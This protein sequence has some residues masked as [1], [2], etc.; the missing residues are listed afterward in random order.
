MSKEENSLY[1]YPTLLECLTSWARSLPSYDKPNSPHVKNI[2][3]SKKAIL[4]HLIRTNNSL[5]L[6]DT[7]EFTVLID[8]L[9]KYMTNAILLEI[10]GRYSK[11]YTILEEPTFLTTQDDLLVINKENPY[12]Q[13]MF[14]LE[15]IDQKD[16]PV[17]NIKNKHPKVII[18]QSEYMLK[19]HVY[20][21]HEHVVKPIKKEFYQTFL[22]AINSKNLSIL[23]SKKFS[24]LF[25]IPE[26]SPEF[27]VIQNYKNHNPIVL[28][29]AISQII[30]LATDY[31]KTIQTDTNTKIKIYLSLIGFI[32]PMP[33]YKIPQESKKNVNKILS[34]IFYPENDSEDQ[35]IQIVKD[36]AKLP[37][38]TIQIFTSPY[39]IESFGIQNI[40]TLQDIAKEKSQSNINPETS[41]HNN[42]DKILQNDPITPSHNQTQ[43]TS[44]I[45]YTI[46]S[47]QIMYN[48][49]M[50]LNPQAHS[51]LL[52][53]IH[54]TLKNKVK[55]MEKI[56]RLLSQILLQF[57]QSYNALIS[58]SLSHSLNIKST[59]QLS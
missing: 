5:L 50:E 55:D 52:K 34:S 41:L 33:N 27:Q 47:L 39:T 42:N 25:S 40:Q 37:V 44:D 35:P 54:A 2:I 56:D 18:E 28:L 4:N 57:P 58:S 48:K 16:K 14:E 12:S 53:E 43:S 22:Q 3:T 6:F 10:L 13:M 29:N 36:T 9:K 17:V 31:I 19:N 38:G 24:T 30:N 11:A 7:K 45:K 32:S 49:T 26:N 59:N 23:K 21:S 51:P 1:K 8:H 46:S 20:S 15:V